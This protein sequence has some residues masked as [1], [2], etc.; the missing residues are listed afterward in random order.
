MP[1]NLQDSLLKVLNGEDSP[2]GRGSVRL[3][4]A[5]S[6]PWGDHVPSWLVSQI[7]S[8]KIYLAYYK[9]GLQYL[10]RVENYVI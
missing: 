3:S 10:C 9:Y 6:E 1:E 5:P 2:K 4:W 7:R 8:A